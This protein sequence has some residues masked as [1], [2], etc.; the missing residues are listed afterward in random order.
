MTKAGF[1]QVNELEAEDLEGD[2]EDLWTT[3]SSMGYNKQLVMDQVNSLNSFP[4]MEAEVKN[5]YLSVSCN[6]ELVPVNVIKTSL[7]RVLVRNPFV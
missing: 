1:V 5:V 6:C 7:S 2:T 4:G 3:L